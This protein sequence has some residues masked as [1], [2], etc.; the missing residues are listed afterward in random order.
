MGVAIS[1]GGLDAGLDVAEGMM[2]RIEDA[3]KLTDKQQIYKDK[4]RSNRFK[5]KD[6]SY[7]IRIN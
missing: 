4:N 3:V 1:F 7:L 5:D 2:N 6:K